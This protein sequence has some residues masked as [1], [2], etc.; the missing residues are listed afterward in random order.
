[1]SNE[2]WRH[3]LGD[4][5]HRTAARWPAKTAILCGA[6]HWTYAQFDALVDDLA[7]G[8]AGEGI[9]T[10]DRVAVLSRNSHAFAAMRFALARLG[11]VLVPINFMLNA[12]E[13]A[14]ILRHAGATSL[15]VGPDLLALGLDAAA[16]DTPV[17]RMFALPG[18]DAAAAP[19]GAAADAVA[20]HARMVDF[21]A[22]VAAGRAAG[23]APRAA[24]DQAMLAQIIYT[25]GTESAPK[26]AQL[27]HEAVIWEYVSCLVEGEIGADDRI[28]HALPLYHCAQ[29]DVFLGPSIYVGAT[30][31]IT[32]KPT[33]DNILPMLAAHRINSFFAPPSIWIALLRS[34]H[35]DGTDLSAL[36]KGYYGASIMPVE[37]L[38]EIQRRLPRV[39]LWNFYGQTEIAPL[40]TVLKPE[41]QLR[42]AG[43]AGRAVLNVETRVVD[44]EMRDV[45]PGEIG[46]IVHRSPQLLQGYYDEPQKTAAAFAGGWFHSGDLATIDDEGYITVVDRRKDMIKTGGEN[47]AS[48]EVEEVVYRLP[49]VA[50]VAVVGLPDPYWIEA[51][52]AI[53]VVKAGA[54][55]TEDD[56]IAHCRAQMAH[57]KAPKR[58]IFV[59]SLPKN[60][61]G[62]LLKREL[63]R[64]YEAAT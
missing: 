5:L 54:G 34:A 16:R 30:N 32:S 25:S 27:T 49:Q 1:M 20:L 61:S 29:L 11:A 43:S 47:V 59:D 8:L 46:E 58:V 60:P 62:K 9:R 23:G 15:C 64:R 17:V 44:D 21:D 12:D 56:V 24:V 37:V 22:L 13:V 4:L 7:G 53:V 31:V 19:A 33:A 45:K 35:F 42:K 39:R 6:V 63:R 48:R 40:A 41:D 57:F 10:G 3:T 52:T 50:E 55:L 38:K 2:I 18:E 14:F 36:A 26:G 28:L 51:V